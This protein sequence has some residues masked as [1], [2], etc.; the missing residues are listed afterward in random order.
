MFHNITAKEL[1]EIEIHS[2]IEYILTD[3]KINKRHTEQYTNERTKKKFNWSKCEN[4][5]C[6]RKT[7]IPKATPKQ[8]EKL[9]TIEYTVFVCWCVIKA[10]ECIGVCNTQNN[11]K[12]NVRCSNWMTLLQESAHI[13]T[14]EKKKQNQQKA[15]IK[16]SVYIQ[17]I[18]HKIVYILSFLNF[19]R[20]IFHRTCF[21]VVVFVL[22]RYFISAVV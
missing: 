13:N 1:K 11:K 15:H 5:T 4:I 20:Y 19:V 6:K 14:K 10:N 7:K 21:F 18:G 12:K 8:V 3:V 2:R 9:L 22:N 16:L 17:V